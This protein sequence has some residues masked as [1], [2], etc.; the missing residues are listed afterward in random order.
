VSA[1][2]AHGKTAGKVSDRLPIVAR[3]RLLLLR[4]DDR[5]DFMRMRIDDDDLV[6]DHDVFVAAPLRIRLRIL[7]AA[8]GISGRCP[9]RGLLRR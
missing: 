7:A 1:S 4:L 5:D 6:A 8:A 9:E 2:Y 3:Y